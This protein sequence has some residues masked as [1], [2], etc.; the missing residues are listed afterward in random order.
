MLLSHGLYVRLFG[1]RICA[2]AIVVATLVASDLARGLGVALSAGKCTNSVRIVRDECVFDFRVAH[3]T[4]R[5]DKREAR[6]REH[7]FGSKRLG[8]DGRRA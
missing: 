3:F 4:C 1:Q 5:Y 8:A 7:S 2:L 6:Q